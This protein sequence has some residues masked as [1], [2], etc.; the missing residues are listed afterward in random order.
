MC[1][2]SLGKININDIKTVNIFTILKVKY[3]RAV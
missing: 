1:K 3:F 2:W